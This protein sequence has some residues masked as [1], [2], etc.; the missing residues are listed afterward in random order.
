MKKIHTICVCDAGT[1][2]SAIGRMPELGSFAVLAY[3][4]THY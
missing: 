3:T 4:I 1:P 2:G